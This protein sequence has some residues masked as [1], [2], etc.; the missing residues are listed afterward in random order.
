[1]HELIIQSEKTLFFCF[2]LAIAIR[3]SGDIL[4]ASKQ[5]FISLSEGAGC[6]SSIRRF[7]GSSL[8]QSSDPS[9]SFTQR[10]KISPLLKAESIIIFLAFVPDDTI[11]LE[12]WPLLGIPGPH[13]RKQQDF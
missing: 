10:A 2:S 8:H 12:V 13:L 3:I 7:N 9:T 11:R 1:M 6:V 5:S 4:H